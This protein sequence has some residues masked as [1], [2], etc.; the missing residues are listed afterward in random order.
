MVVM[1]E[2]WGDA[3]VWRVEARDAAHHPAMH[4]IDLTPE[5]DLAPNANSADVEKPCAVCR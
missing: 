5:N 2:G 1:T 3:G 4:R